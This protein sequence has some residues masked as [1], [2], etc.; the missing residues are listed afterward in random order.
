MTTNISYYAF[1][2]AYMLCILPHWYAI[3]LTKSS[4]DLPGFKNLSP[5]EFI[6]KCRNLEKQTPV[7][8]K[9]L[10]AEAAQQNGFENLPI[11]MASIVA[12]NLAGLDTGLMNKLAVAYLASRAAYN[13][14][15]LLI[16]YH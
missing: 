15:A 11:F 3:G 10:R 2:A 14:S 7:V 4:K 9:Y 1:P 12:G 13:A 5:R 8:A 16:Q 6:V